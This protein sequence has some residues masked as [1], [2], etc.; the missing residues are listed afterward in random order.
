MERNNLDSL[1]RN[2]A[3]KHKATF[4]DSDWE[5][6]EQLIEAEESKRRFFFWLK[7]VLPIFIVGSLT[8]LYFYPFDKGKGVFSEKMIEEVSE[9]SKPLA[10]VKSKKFET[11]THKNTSTKNQISE[12]R[13]MLVNPPKVEVVKT[14]TGKNVSNSLNTGNTKLSIYPKKDP[15]FLTHIIDNSKTL[16]RSTDI[17]KQNKEVD[18]KIGIV[19]GKS[20]LDSEIPLFN[21]I[22][23]PLKAAMKRF[24]KGEK[25][26]HEQIKKSTLFV[27][28]GPQEQFLSN[29]GSTSDF[30]FGTSMLYQE[31]TKLAYYGGFQYNSRGGID[32]NYAENVDQNGVYFSNSITPIKAYY[33]DIPIGIEWFYKTNN[34]LN[35]GL[36]TS[37]YITSKTETKSTF[38]NGPR[39]N[40]ESTSSEFSRDDKFSNVLLGLNAGYSYYF[41]YG[42]SLGMNVMYT[43][44][45]ILKKDGF[46]D[47]NTKQMMRLQLKYA[48]PIFQ[49]NKRQ[50]R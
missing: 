2:A 23:E 19:E 32:I 14:I 7:F 42:S 16:E 47:G 12:N 38:L 44:G 28:A 18:P 34:T 15:S 5:K 37:V 31:N 1:F 39:I 43:P 30:F 49:G 27:S 9:K 36:L 22:Q 29:G 45:S 48:Y 17:S 11:K 26:F 6:M 3:S 41:K 10:P 25:P 8:A 40:E 46:A 35:V 13:E 24:E 4:A 21:D 50:I 20:T 33:I